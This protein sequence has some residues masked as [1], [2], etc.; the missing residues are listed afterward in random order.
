MEWQWMEKKNIVKVVAGSILFIVLAF[1]SWQAFL[2]PTDG[3]SLT[4]NEAEDMVLER[5]DGEITD[6][7]LA[8]DHYELKLKS[9]LGE[10]KIRISKE[11][12]QIV[13]IAQE[14]AAEPVENLDKTAIK[15]IIAEEEEGELTELTTRGKGKSLFYDAVVKSDQAEVKL[16]LEGQAGTIVKRSETKIEQPKKDES[17]VAKGDSEKKQTEKKPE[18]EKPA[19]PQAEAPS[20][21]EPEKPKNITEAEAIQIALDTVY[22]EVDDVDLETVNG[23]L[24]YFIE[25]ERDDDVEADIQINAITGE[26]ISIEWDD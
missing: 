25:I 17:D 14:K 6:I 12:G 4:E 2:T 15:K 19:P 13:E 26:V 1:V 10:Y 7:K 8:D 20:K 5:F 18:A 16:T 11:K 24:F 3:E 21:K 9:D 23:Q 22:G